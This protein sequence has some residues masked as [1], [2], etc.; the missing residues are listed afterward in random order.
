MHKQGEYIM[1]Q[2]AVIQMDTRE[3]LAWEAELQDSI[4]QGLVM[5]CSHK[6]LPASL[7]AFFVSFPCPAEPYSCAL[8]G[9]DWAQAPPSVSMLLHLGFVADGAI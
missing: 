1:T 7:L 6:G 5:K 9:M 4:W 2:A 8:S 3:I